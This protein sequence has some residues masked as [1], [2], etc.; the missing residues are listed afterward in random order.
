ML[1]VGPEKRCAS[2]GRLGLRKRVRLTGA[3]A[4][5]ASVATRVDPHELSPP[6]WPHRVEATG[7][8]PPYA[9]RVLDAAFGCVPEGSSRGSL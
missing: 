6:N 7:L 4:N 3:G 1:M 5:K 8:P 9:A 2:G